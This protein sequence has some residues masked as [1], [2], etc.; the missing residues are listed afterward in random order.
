[1]EISRRNGYIWIGFF[2]QSHI[3]GGRCGIGKKYFY[4]RNYYR[5][6]VEKEEFYG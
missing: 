1:M 2:G 5:L 4:R 6:D 3:A